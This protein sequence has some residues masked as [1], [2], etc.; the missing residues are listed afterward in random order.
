MAAG[1]ERPMGLG[2][3]RIEPREVVAEHDPITLHADDLLPRD[4][5]HASVQPSLQPGDDERPV[6]AAS[7]VAPRGEPASRAHEHPDDLRRGEELA[8]RT[9]DLEAHIDHPAES[10][11]AFLDGVGPEHL[12]Q[13]HGDLRGCAR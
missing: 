8:R 13:D 10:R 1:F 11:P 7:L 4:E 3:A 5:E 12:T 9:R 2:D 6:F